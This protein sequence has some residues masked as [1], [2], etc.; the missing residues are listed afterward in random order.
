MQ[1]LDIVW[2]TKDNLLGRKH[3]GLERILNVIDV[4]LESYF[5]GTSQ[6]GELAKKSSFDANETSFILRKLYFEESA[7]SK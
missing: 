3:Q 6:F 1:K 2:K 4:S 7:C 5:I